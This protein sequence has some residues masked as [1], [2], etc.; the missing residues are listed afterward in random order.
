MSVPEL[1]IDL[2]GDPLDRWSVL[3]PKAETCRKMLAAYVKDLGGLDEF[4]PLLE[5]YADAHVPAE[6]LAEMKAIAEIVEAPE[7]EVILANLYYD[8]MSFML[9]CTAFAVD[10]PDGPLHA[11]NLDWW[12]PS[13]EL[14]RETIVY[15]FTRGGE[16]R[17]QTV[18]WPG[19][20]GALSGMAPGRFAITLNAVL[21]DD[22]PQ[23]ALP[24]SSLIR[25]VLDSAESYD[26]AVQRLSETTVVSSSLLLVTGTEPGEM[27]V[28]ER[29]PTRSAVRHPNNGSIVVTNDYRLIDRDEPKVAVNDLQATSC[30]R[31]DR[32]TELIGIN[33]PRSADDALTILSDD[34]VR[35]DITE[36]QM[37][38]M[39]RCSELRLEVD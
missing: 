33:S 4:G 10:T 37:A 16:L 7:P 32:A 39:S 2:D 35:M 25:D 3:K 21:S 5:Q 14:S 28:I 30:G 22:A 26:E 18:S 9:G 11:R 34:H 12:S 23:L 13:G 19:Y 27:C 24:I 6:H 15:T 1:T 17:F 38:F 29:T 8:A 20:V 36:Q 31:F